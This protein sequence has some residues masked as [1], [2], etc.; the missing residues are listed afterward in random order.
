MISSFMGQ[1]VVTYEHG[2]TPLT[3]DIHLNDAISLNDCDPRT[4]KCVSTN[5]D[6]NTNIIP[7]C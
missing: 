6:V 5:N 2:M 3:G 4:F 7:N 1:C